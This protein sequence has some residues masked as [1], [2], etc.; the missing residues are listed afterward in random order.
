MQAPREGAK[1]EE[2]QRALRGSPQPGTES[3]TLY[4]LLYIVCKIR[5]RKTLALLWKDTNAN[6]NTASNTNTNTNTA[7]LTSV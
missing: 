1:H 5:I 7:T 2:E 4:G 6:T 3:E